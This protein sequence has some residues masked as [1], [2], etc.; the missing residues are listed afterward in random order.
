MT[1]SIVT[2]EGLSMLA[3][4]LLIQNTVLRNKLDTVETQRD[5]LLEALEGLMV[6]ESECWSDI[7]V[8]GFFELAKTAIAKAKGEVR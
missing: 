4:D 6:L 3:N 1:Q 5:E 8:K 7:R 2:I